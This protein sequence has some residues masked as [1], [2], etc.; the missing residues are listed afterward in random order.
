MIYEVQWSERISCTRFIEASSAREAVDI[1]N[2]MGRASHVPELPWNTTG[3]YNLTEMKARRIDPRTLDK[4]AVVIVGG[5]YAG[6]N[7]GGPYK[8]FATVDAGAFQ[9]RRR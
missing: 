2:V 4:D 6:E 9:P 8:E 5:A 1:S 3:E 7:E